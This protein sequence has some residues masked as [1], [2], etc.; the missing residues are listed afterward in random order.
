MIF[1][2]RF[3]ERRFEKTDAGVIVVGLHPRR[4]RPRRTDQFQFVRSYLHGGLYQRYL[5]GRAYKLSWFAENISHGWVPARAP[6]PNVIF[7]YFCFRFQVSFFSN[8]E[9]DSNSAY[10]SI[11]IYFEEVSIL[12]IDIYIYFVRFV[13][14]WIVMISILPVF[15]NPSLVEWCQN[16][17]WFLHV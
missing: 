6:N 17:F 13:D 12:N 4:S 3:H 2:P 10:Q 7:W 16:D 8:R 11:S 9:S 15:S 5:R 14:I 1:R